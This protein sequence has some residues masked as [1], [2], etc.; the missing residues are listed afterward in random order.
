M[1]HFNGNQYDNFSFNPSSVGT[2]WVSGNQP[3]LR[4]PNAVISRF[5]IDYVGPKNADNYYKTSL[6]YGFKGTIENPKKQVGEGFGTDRDQYSYNPYIWG[7]AVAHQRMLND[8]MFIMGMEHAGR[9]L[10]AYGDAGV[11]IN[12]PKRDISDVDVVAAEG[13]VAYTNYPTEGW[14]SFGKKGDKERTWVGNSW[15]NGMA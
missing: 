11:S 12:A 15:I 1:A 5:N 9:N 3:S 4:A 6:G 14:S 7:L 2:D 13:M 10:A 8:S